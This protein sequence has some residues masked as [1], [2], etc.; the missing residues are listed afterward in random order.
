MHCADRCP[1]ARS[2]SRENTTLRAE[3]DPALVS[4]IPN[5]V[6]PDQ[7][8]PDPSLADPEYSARAARYPGELAR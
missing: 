6:V 1:A 7:F 8:L 4:V 5:A 2:H 3:L